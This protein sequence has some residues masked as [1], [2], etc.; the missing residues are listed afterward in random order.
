MEVARFER[1]TTGTAAAGIGSAISFA[2]EF[3]PGSSAVSG[4]IASLWENVSTAAASMTFSTWKSGVGISEAM[5]ITNSGNVGIGIT[6]PS[7]Y[8]SNAD[9]LV[10]GSIGVNDKNGITIVGGDTDGRGAI[11]FADTTQN[12]AGYI[13]YKHADNSMLF[14]TSD[15][16]RI[17]IDSAGSIQFNNYDS[18]NQTGTPTYLLG[19]DG[20]GNV[21]KTNTIPGSAA[22]PY[23]PLAGGTMTGD[24]NLTYAYPRINLTDTNHNSDYSII[25]NDGTFSIYDITNN[26]HRLSI[27][28]AGNATF[29]GNVTVSGTSSSFNTGNSGTFVTNDASNYPRFTMTNASAQVGLFR[30]GGNAGGMYIGGS[31]DGFRL[32]TSSFSQKLFIDTNGNATFSGKIT[33]GNDIVNATAGVYTWTGDTDTYIQRSAGNE[34]TFKTGASTALVLNSSQNATFSAKAYG[35]APITSDPDSTIATKGYVQSV[36]TGATIYRG[37]WNPDVSLNS[38][39]GNPNLNTV[40]QTSGYYY[41]C[42]ADGAATPNGATTEPNTWNTGDWVIWNDDVGTSGEWQKIDN[43]SVLSGVGTGQTVALWQGPSTVTDSETLGNAPITVSGSDTTFTGT[44]TSDKHTINSSVDGIL[45]LNQ[46]G[47]DTGW[48]YIEFNTLGGR[49]WYVGMDNNKNFDIYNDNIDS[50]GLTIDYTNND[51]TF[52]GSINGGDINLSS[53]NNAIIDPLSVGNILRFTDND[54]TQN[55]NQITGTI[56]WET[57]DSNNP[58]IQ[59]FITTNSTNQG[60]GRLVFG[61]GLGGSAVEKMRIDSDGNVGIGVTAPDN[62]LMVQGDST[63]GAASAGN[64]ALFEGPSGTNGLKVFVDDTENAAG[65]QTIS[66]DDLLI[67]PHGG[68][69]GIGTAGPVVKLEI[70]DSTHTTMKIRSGNN[71]NILFAQAIQSNDARIGT[72]TNTPLAFYTNASERMRITSA[73]NVGI[74]ND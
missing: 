59:S 20:S 27:S 72:D 36:I 13:T 19:T 12:S 60:K 16:T 7:S 57:K 18:T 28:A 38:G 32:Y 63:N 67:N 55:N 17:I 69:V 51:A 74:G 24:L 26:S 73:G 50:L 6:N 58:G 39:Y 46:T 14:G 4:Q 53:T 42:S 71:D 22:G 8:D 15:A 35:V 1:Q 66:A 5:R 29:A 43:S 33:S 11:Y 34:I 37:T 48:N 62:K 31:G 44:L 30:A 2:S 9:N 49:Q 56:E 10:I 45:T 65:F 25:N 54:P 21:V 23:L 47:A 64:V 68:N 3:Q 61:T 52:G 41:I 70:Q 40:T